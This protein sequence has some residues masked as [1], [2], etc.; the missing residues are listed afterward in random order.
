[1]GSTFTRKFD[2]S[3]KIADMFIALAG[4]TLEAEEQA[5]LFELVFEDTRNLLSRY[6]AETIDQMYTNIQTVL[7]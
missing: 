4:E 1:M 2:I 6:N 7:Y 5:E 3:S